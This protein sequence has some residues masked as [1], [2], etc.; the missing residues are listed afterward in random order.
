[1]KS[2]HGCYCRSSG[3]LTTCT[4]SARD[5]RALWEL[6]KYL[7]I[8]WTSFWNL[9]QAQGGTWFLFHHLV[10][11]GGSHIGRCRT[12]WRRRSRS[13]HLNPAVSSDSSTYNRIGTMLDDHSFGGRCSDGPAEKARKLLVRSECY[14]FHVVHSVVLLKFRQDSTARKLAWNGL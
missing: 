7:N 12:V 10:G 13:P 11:Y 6:L 3:L 5:S 14:C 2:T 1:M 8:V 9:W 4:K